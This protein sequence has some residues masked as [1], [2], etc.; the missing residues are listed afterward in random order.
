MTDFIYKRETCRLCDS[1]SLELVMPLTSTPLADSYV[2]KDHV[3]EVQPVYPLNLY[4]CND[5]GFSQLLDIVIPQVIYRDYIYET[6]SSLGLVEHFRNYATDVFDKIRPSANGLVVDIG[7]NDGS[8]LSFFK[9]YG[10]RV[11]GVDPAERIAKRATDSGIETLPEFFTSD[12]GIAIQEK[13]GSASIITA[14]N[15]YA[16]V[17]DLKAL[18]LAIRDLLT[19]NGVFVFESFYLADWMENMVFDFT[20]HEHLS[21][22]SVKPLQVFFSGLGMELIDVERISTKGGSIRCTI[23]RAGGPRHVTSNVSKMISMETELGLHN[24]V[25]FQAF[26]KRID[27]AKH[28]VLDLVEPLVS[29]GKTIAG[30]GASATTT[31]LLYHFGLGDK[32]SFILDDYPAKQNLYSPGYHIPV[33]GPD[34]LYER[35]PDFVMIL[36][37]RYAEPIIEK[38]KMYLERGGRFIVPLPDLKVI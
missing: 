22:F 38:H 35:S 36:A 31:T 37:W 27:T 33:L 9:G 26:A 18:T 2:D 28:N 12:L 20:Y 4:L 25:T 5:C 34:A 7:S 32:L 11:L 6:V 19:D 21:Y 29:K 17:D 24:A 15:L 23:Q 10:M 8:L 16:N 1:K 3:N 14:N 13:Y 30:Y